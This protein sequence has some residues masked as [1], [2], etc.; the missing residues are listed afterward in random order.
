MQYIKIERFILS[1]LATASWVTH[2][3]ANEFTDEAKEI[4]KR[5]CLTFIALVVTE[6]GAKEAQPLLNVEGVDL[7]YLAPHDFFLTRNGHGA[8]FWDKPE[9]YGGQENVDR[10][11]AIAEK[12]GTCDCF[13]IDGSETLLTLE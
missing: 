1:Y 9:K 8:G 3:D 10:L 11:T 13:L 7:N 12:M 4:A 2:N 6:F 5:D